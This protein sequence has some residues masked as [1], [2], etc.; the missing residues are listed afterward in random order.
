MVKNIS[1]AE[2]ILGGLNKCNIDYTVVDDGKA[3]EDV[4]VLHSPSVDDYTT[5]EDV[6]YS[7]LE[8]LTI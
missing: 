7:P 5:Q 3:Q 4:D 6:D 1:K 2:Y 8:D